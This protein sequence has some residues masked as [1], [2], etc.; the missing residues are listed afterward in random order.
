MEYSCE[1]N[2]DKD[3]EEINKVHNLS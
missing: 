3:I 1:R 2:L